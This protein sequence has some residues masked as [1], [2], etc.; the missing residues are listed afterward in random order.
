MI[1]RPGH[2]ADRT[3][4]VGTPQ[5]VDGLDLDLAAR[6]VAAAG[7]SAERFRAAFGAAGGGRIRL[8]RPCTSRGHRRMAR[9]VLGLRADALSRIARAMPT[10]AETR[11]PPPWG[12]MPRT[13]SPSSNTSAVTGSGGRAAPSSAGTSARSAA[14]GVSAAPGRSPPTDGRP[15]GADGAFAVRTGRTMVADRRRRVGVAADAAPRGRRARGGPRGTGIPRHLPGLLPRLDPRGGRGMSAMPT[16]LER[17]R[18]TLRRS[19]GAC[20]CTT[21]SSIRRGRGAGG[22]GVVQLPAVDHRGPRHGHGL[23]RCRRMGERVRARARPPLPRAEHAPGRAED[24]S[25]AARAMQAAGAYAIRDA[26]LSL[27]SNLWTDLLVNSRSRSSSAVATDPASPGS[28][29]C[30]ARCTARRATR[31]AGSGGSTSARTSCSGIFRR[32]PCAIRSRRRWPRPRA[33]EPEVPIDRIPEK[34]REAE[35]KLRER[36][37]DAQRVA[38]ELAAATLTRRP[39]MPIPSPRSC[40]PSR[41]MPCPGR[42]GSAS[43]SRRISS[44]P[45]PTTRWPASPSRAPPTRP[46]RPRASSVAC[47]PTGGAEG[48]PAVT[49]RRRE[50]PERRTGT[51]PRRLATLELYQDTNPDDVLAAWYRAEAAGGSVRSRSGRRSRPCPISPARSRLWEVG[52]DLADL[53]W[54]ASLQAAGV[55]VP[56]VTTRRR[57]FLVDDPPPVRTDS[58][59]TCTSTAPDPCRTRGMA[60]PP[61]SRARSSRCPCSAGEGACA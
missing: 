12:W 59:S 30:R 31:R 53:D 27:L 34:H 52:D 26:D 47:S 4:P 19:C 58:W 56:G 24:P 23:R 43:S 28:C 37:R 2:L 22:A 60:R 39:S 54:P 44:I 11:S 7:G 25:S 61:C 5:P 42:C 16:S 57:S 50:R 3:V 36:R 29:A 35:R 13:S 48:R 38:D 17:A 49:S 33:P 14:S 1:R 15:L 55:V 46:R 10:A 6:N 18:G 40:G 45:A 9:G 32:A 8:P 51:D 21:P 41:G 20:T